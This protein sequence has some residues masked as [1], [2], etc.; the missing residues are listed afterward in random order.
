VSVTEQARSGRVA[1]QHR[2]ETVAGV[3]AEDDEV[4]LPELGAWLRYV[5]G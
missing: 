3:G 1:K 2:A 4:L 5:P